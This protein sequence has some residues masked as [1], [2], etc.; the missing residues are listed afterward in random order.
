MKT[1]VSISAAKKRSFCFLNFDDGSYILCSI[2]LVSKFTLKKGQELEDDTIQNIIQKQN[3]YDCRQAALN[4]A[5]YSLRTEKQVI[6]ALIKKGFS[7][8]VA[9][10]GLQ[11]VKEFGYV[12][13]QVFCE[14]FIKAKVQRRYY[15]IE[16]IRRELTVKGID[17]TMI[18]DSIQSFYPIES[19]QVYAY[20]SAQKKLRSI[21]FKTIQ[22]QKEAV[23]R[24]LLIQ[25]YSFDIIKQTINK[26]I[27]DT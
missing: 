21:S 27:L 9:E 18:N 13:N 3:I 10:D 5:T 4:Y 15:G 25:G 23:Y 7:N 1:I 11:F 14:Q 20:K 2:D 16:R 12:S 19:L 24:H 22:K 26:I 17:A 8:T 6:D